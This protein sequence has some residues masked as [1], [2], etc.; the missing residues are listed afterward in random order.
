MR[1][2]YRLKKT[3]LSILAFLILAPV[4]AQA[5]D[6]NSIVVFGGS[7]SDSG[8]F[9]AVTGFAN[10]APYDLLDELVVPTGPY[11]VGGNHSSNGA[12]WV[13][14]F[15]RPIGMSRYVEPAFRSASPFA[16][17]Y[18][19]AGARSTDVALTF[20]MPEQIATF[21][22]D[23]GNVA[24][25]DALYV[26]DFGG[27]D[28]RDALI[29]ALFGGN[30]T[31]IIEA[32]AYSVAANMLQLYNAGGQGAGA[33]KFLLLTVAD[34]GQIPSIRI[35]DDQ[36]QAG[37]LIMALA[38]QLTQGFNAGVATLLGAM[39][40]ANAEIAVLDVY[41]TVHA[42]VAN[43]SDF[44]LINVTDPCI[45]PNVPPFTCNA[46][47]GYLFWDGIHPT[48]IVHGIFAEEAASV[49]GQ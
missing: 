6:F 48:K 30:P 15:A 29:V 45:T 38:S 5:M 16:A 42:M 1:P 32:A 8:N 36:L 18:A 24:P 46:P 19:A 34:I 17:N 20:D 40:P 13:E 26:I 47:D 28:V 4:Q 11:H 25:S 41:G 33:R 37:G 21:L 39:L 31:P 7:V 27:N 35:L 3:L 10:K 22:Q 9:F 43:P 44:G 12:T 23:R 49:L 2:I 14:Q